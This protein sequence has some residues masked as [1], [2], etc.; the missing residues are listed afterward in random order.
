MECNDVRKGMRVVTAKVRPETAGMSIKE[1][2]LK[3]RRPGV[4]GIVGDMVAGH[5]GD[6]WWVEHEGSGD[7]GAYCFDEFELLAVKGFEGITSKE[8]SDEL[9]RRGVQL[10]TVNKL[11]EAERSAKAWEDTA[12]RYL[13]NAEFYSG[14]LRDCY[15]KLPEEMKR[16][17]RFN[18][19]HEVGDEPILSNLP[20]VVKFLGDLAY[21]WI[22][23]TLSAQGAQAVL[24]EVTTRLS[25]AGFGFVADGTVY[26][27]GI[28]VHRLAVRENHEPTAKP[29]DRLLPTQQENPD[30]LHGRYWIRKADGRLCDPDAIYF[31]LRLDKGGSDPAHLKAGRFA[32]RMY[33]LHLQISKAAHLEQLA[34]ELSE[35][36]DK[37]DH[38]EQ[39]DFPGFNVS[40]LRDMLG[41]PLAFELAVD[42]NAGQEVQAEAFGA[43]DSAKWHKERGA[44]MKSR[45]DELEAKI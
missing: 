29:G 18:D 42:Y 20:D 41:N 40:E 21:V 13:E 28:F 37:I 45:A 26:G 34:K 27:N 15:E 5:G 39:V 1:E 32:A 10:E 33:A 16:R 23:G 14:I 8:L 36:C 19:E 9:E 6:V 38:D 31:V 17:A 2:F 44:F 35:L 4:V 3:T 30:G 7:V 25:K 11:I 12:A 24:D 43:D 22:P